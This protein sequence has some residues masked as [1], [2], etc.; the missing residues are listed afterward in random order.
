M[1]SGAGVC[2]EVVSDRQQLCS[3]DSRTTLRSIGETLNKWRRHINVLLACCIIVLH[4]NHANNSHAIYA[5][6]YLQCSI[7]CIV[8]ITI[9]L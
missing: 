2:R 7:I 5:Y 9:L 8:Q 6:T 4:L 3:R 1:A